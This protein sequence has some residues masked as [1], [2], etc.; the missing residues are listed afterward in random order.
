MAVG[1]YGIVCMGTAGEKCVRDCVKSGEAV[2][3]RLA[4]FPY[5]DEYDDLIRSD[6]L[7]I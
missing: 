4:E 2:Y 5:W 7:R 3:E 1:P 6:N